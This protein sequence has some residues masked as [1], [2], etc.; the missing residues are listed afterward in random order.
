MLCSKNLKLILDKTK[1]NGFSGVQEL[2]VFLYIAENTNSTN[3]EIAFNN[4]LSLFYVKRILVNLKQKE[5]VNS[6]DDL[7]DKSNSKL[8]RQLYLLSQKGQKL[9]LQAFMND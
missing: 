8:K 2:L 6:A 1:E 9:Y 4:N 3:K 7:T 5:L